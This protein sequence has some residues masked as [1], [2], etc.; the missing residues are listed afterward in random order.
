MTRRND[1]VGKI[2]TDIIACWLL[3]KA[4]VELISIPVGVSAWFRD[5]S[6]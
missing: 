5:K 4:V 3:L 6:S 1:G 2:A